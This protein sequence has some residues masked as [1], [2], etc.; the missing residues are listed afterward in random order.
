MTVIHRYGAGAASHRERALRHLRSILYALVLAPAVWVLCG[1]GFSSDLTGRARDATGSVETV[2][3]ILLLVLAGAAYAILVFAPISP[4]GPALAGLVFLGVAVW[5][6]VA[7]ES[8]AGVWP[9][10]VTKEGFDLSRP[11][12]ALA[13]LLAVPMVCTA[14]SARRWARYEP[15]ELP[16]IG[17]LGR[18]RGTAAAPGTPVAVERTA[19]ISTADPT[20]VVPAV[21]ARDEPTVAVAEPAHD[22]PT[23]AVE[24]SAAAE[25]A[26]AENAVAGDATEE[27]TVAEPARDEAVTEAVVAADEE[28]ETT[29]VVD[30]DA[31]THPIDHGGVTQVTGPGET[32]QVILR[33]EPSEPTTREQVAANR[34]AADQA[35][36]DRVAQER[37]RQAFRDRAAQERAR[38]AFE[39]RAA[40]AA[41]EA[42]ESTQRIE[43][44]G[45]RTQII[46]LGAGTVQPPGDSTQVLRIPTP[47]PAPAEQPVPER[48]SI[49]GQERPDPGADPTTRLVPLQLRGD[50][51]DE[52]DPGEDEP[53]G[54]D[55]DEDDAGAPGEDTT[56][57]V[58]TTPRPRSLLDLE[59]P[60][61]EADD[62]TRRLPQQRRP[63]HDDEEETTHPL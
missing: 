48:E 19:V 18:A 15:P 16:L 34:A 2:S 21:T 8:Y 26:V 39:D 10:A 1:V 35:E 53:G 31:A 4:L 52:E 7:P 57:D 60:A 38:Q 50:L 36:Q 37:S 45:D 27:D 56:A 22:E 12:H 23:V 47:A 59:R 17:T 44:P 28:V 43:I 54:G 63:A 32:T 20:E 40:R 55:P 9:A 62:D 46:S 33:R 61:D 25:D 13:A 30:P 6:L 42:G 49:V 5:A 14:L 3:A 41:R 51:R 29:A 11:G 58:G 24:E